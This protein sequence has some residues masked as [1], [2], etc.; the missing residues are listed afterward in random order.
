MWAEI[1]LTPTLSVVASSPFAS[2]CFA[3][4]GILSLWHMLLEA[5]QYIQGT[6]FLPCW[7]AALPLSDPPQSAI[8]TSVPRW[9]LPTFAIVI[10]AGTWAAYLFVREMVRSL[11][12][13]WKRLWAEAEPR[14]G[15]RRKAI[16]EDDEPGRLEPLGLQQC[17]WHPYFLWI[18]GK[19]HEDGRD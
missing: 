12:R 5:A 2:W 14:A 19:C 13:Q 8:K 1:L 11:S 4:G 18:L 17:P 10:N 15:L 6:S 9:G 16:C 3:M 7:A